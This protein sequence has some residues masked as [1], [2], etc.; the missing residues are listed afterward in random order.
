MAFAGFEAKAAEFS[1]VLKMGRTQLQDAVPMTLGQEFSTYAVMLGE[2]EQRL[3]EACL[4]IHEINLGATAIG[5][6]ITAPEGYSALAIR[7]LSECS[8]IALV[9][10][11][12]LI[13]ATSDTGVFV[14]FQNGEAIDVGSQTSSGGV[15][16]ST[17]KCARDN[18]RA[19]MLMR[20]LAA[21]ETSVSLRSNDQERH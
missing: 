7:Y 16:S 3:R 15:A 12:D 6:G 10:A 21:M 8:G 9:P 18:S 14:T 13:E 17:L 5:T 4:L 1:D 11:S 2:D 20:C 19:G